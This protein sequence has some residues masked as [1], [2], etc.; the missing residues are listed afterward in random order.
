MNFYFTVHFRCSCLS[1]K[2]RNDKKY[3]QIFLD[4]GFD[5]ALVQRRTFEFIV[6]NHGKGKNSI[7]LVKP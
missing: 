5:E 7:K 1:L 2:Y 4:E 3:F 6:E